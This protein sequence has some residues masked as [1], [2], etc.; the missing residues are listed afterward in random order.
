VCLGMTGI[1][2]TP[3]EL[4]SECDWT[5]GPCF[6]L[7]QLLFGGGNWGSN[8][9][10]F[11]DRHAVVIIDLSLPL[12]KPAG[13]YATARLCLAYGGNPVAP[14]RRAVGQC[15]AACLA[16][17]AA[18]CSGRPQVGARCKACQSRWTGPAHPRASREAAVGAL[19]LL[20]AIDAQ[21]VRCTTLNQINV[22]IFIFHQI[23]PEEQ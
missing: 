3:P 6:R 21:P 12:L 18:S 10:R 14:R 19:R 22:L 4:E 13:R 15:R 20:Q 23:L 5:S 2:H 8:Y 1:E 17:D 11:S 7:S 9:S 16:V